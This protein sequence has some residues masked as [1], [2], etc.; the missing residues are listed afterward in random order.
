MVYVTKI[1]DVGQHDV[2]DITVNNTNCFRL[3]SAIYAHNS[4]LQD[5]RI[6]RF[7]DGIRVYFDYAQM[8]VRV[9]AALAN[10][11][12]LRDAFNEGKDIHR[13]IASKIYKKPEDRITDGERKN[14]K[15]SVFA[16]LYGKSVE[17]FAE[18]VFKGDI[19][20][21]QKLFNDF[22]DGFPQIRKYVEEKHRESLRTGKVTSMFGDPMYVDMPEYAL[23][24]SDSLKDMLVKD[25]YGDSYSI[26][27][28]P[29]TDNDMKYKIGK[30]LRNA[31]N[32]PIQNTGSALAAI[33]IENIV[34]FIK[35]EKLSTK[36]D[37]FTHD[38]ATIDSQI[39]DL[40]YLLT[41]LKEEAVTI[42]REKYNVPVD[43]DYKIGISGNKMLSLSDTTIEGDIIKSGYDGELETLNLLVEK[44]KAWGVEVSYTIDDQ[45][46][47]IV[48]LEELFTTKRAYSSNVGLPFTVVSGNIELNFK[49]V[50]SS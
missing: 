37:C 26:H 33:C 29:E 21:A 10:E 35:K 4:E 7:D 46:E 5:L 2:Y 1:E 18:E 14:A 6:S 32:Y 16:L 49:G 34:K 38:S 31:Q 22:F 40:P 47:D 27:P 45:K 48:P 11:D 41:S 28:N 9:L 25:T 44:F 36:V 23:T 50:Q 17:N 24:L 20:E 43:I 42:P 39:K 30:A 8:E 19:A 3:K 13:F 12:K 15:Q